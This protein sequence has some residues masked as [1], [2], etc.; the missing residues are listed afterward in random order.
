MSP[1]YAEKRKKHVPKI[2]S[3]NTRCKGLH[4]IERPV[5]YSSM[6]LSCVDFCPLKLPFIFH[7]ARFCP[8]MAVVYMAVVYILFTVDSY[9]GS[10]NPPA[11]STKF[12]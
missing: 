11:V 5:N 2:G 3:E 10:G 9:N 1:N 7:R 8:K 12:Q 6:P 4:A